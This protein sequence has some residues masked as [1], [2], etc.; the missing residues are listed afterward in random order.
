MDAAGVITLGI[1]SL[2]AGLGIIN[3]W[4]NFSSD[5]VKLK[6]N[7]FITIASALPSERVTHYLEEDRLVMG[8]QI[9]NLSSFPVTVMR[10]GIDYGPEFKGAIKYPGYDIGKLPRRLESHD[11]C[12]LYLTTALDDLV[13]RGRLHLVVETAEGKVFKERITRIGY[14][15]ISHIVVQRF[16]LLVFSS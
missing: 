12:I 15:H 3:T 7:H 16:Y 10:M 5:Q 8:V 6:V 1:A 13:D 14:K 11:I 2:G 4:R 9:V